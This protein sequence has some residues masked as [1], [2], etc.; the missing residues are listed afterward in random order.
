MPPKAEKGT[1]KSVDIIDCSDVEGGAVVGMTTTSNTTASHPSPQL[2][3]TLESHSFWKAGA[4]DVGHTTKRP[5]D[6]GQLE[7][8]RVHPKFLHSN[9][10]SHRWAFGA[11]A[12]LLDNA[13]DEI[14]N[15][16]TFVKVD[17]IDVMKDNSPALLFHD[18]GGGMPPERIRNC[19]S[20][21]F[22][23]K[24]SNTTIG[25]YGN[26]FKTS[27][28]R[29]GAD[30]IVF[31][32]ATTASR[33]TQSIGLLSYTFLRRTGQDDVIVPMIDF[34]VSGHWAEPIIY[35]SQDDWS[36]NLK[37]I[38]EWSPFPSKEELMLQFEDIGPHGT[39]VIIYNL[40][41]NDEGIYELSFDDD[42]E[43]IR[44]RDEANQGG[45]TNLRRKTIELQS[46]IS[47]RIRYSLRAYV[48]ILYLRKFS[49]FS[50]ILRGKPVQQLHIADELK[51]TKVI[52]YKPRLGGEES[53]VTVETTFGFVKEAPSIWV[54]GLNVYHKNRL[55][56]P[57]WK[58]T[59][60]GSSKGNGVVGIIEANFIEPAHD[61]QDFER[62]SVFVR[63]EARMK[64]ILL[65][66]WKNHCH[67]VGFQPPSARAHHEQ[68]Q[69][70]VQL[71]V[72]LAAN[73]EQEVVQPMDGLPTNIG[74]D[75][76][77]EK[78]TS[79]DGPGSISIDQI[80]EE[81]I[82]LFVRC[83]E[84]MQKEEEL[85]QTA[86]CLEKELEEA[87]RKLAQISSYLETRRKQKMMGLQIEKF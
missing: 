20:L 7:H 56:R 38:L 11:I 70:H 18:D 4:Y 85:K 25:Q 51:Y 15:G 83:E 62:S 69:S 78:L 12:E 66:Y 72:G 37:V 3:R 21:G 71:S 19:M 80:C 48:S 77:Q 34:D 36:S 10:T 28:M 16:A 2:Q 41:L 14:H 61:K 87:K 29:L 13:V 73:V 52:A 68:K 5:P 32:R 17:K 46:H 6:D 64:Q 67:L 86:E 22:S 84:H 57:F 35:G 49:N 30:V 8:A 76:S 26:G 42:D 39:K 74:Q 60:D 1:V 40:W 44:L 65:D 82:Q 58:I 27:T 55:I 59:A 47:Y 79:R 24:K 75:G 45:L 9:A 33:A 43:D 23:S 31:T 53:E 63:L 50:I 54:S 81:N